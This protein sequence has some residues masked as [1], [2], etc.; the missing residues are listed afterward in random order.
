M[1]FIGKIQ[2]QLYSHD[3]IF[4]IPLRFSPRWNLRVIVLKDKKYIGIDIGGTQLRAALYPEDGIE[5]I[6]KKIIATHL[7]DEKPEDRL[8]DLISEIWPE[9]GGVERIGIAVPGPVD[10]KNGIVYKASNVR[11]WIDL[12]LGSLVEG[13]HKTAVILGNDA[14]LAALG[15]WRYGA[16]IGHHDLIY[17]TISTGIGGGFIIDDRMLVGS[18]GIAGEVGH[19]TVLPDGPICGCGQRGHL[20]SVASGTGIANYVENRLK[21][22]AKSVLSLEPQKPTSRQIAEA[23]AKGDSLAIEAFEYAGTFIGR[24]ITDLLHLFNPTVIVL[25]GGVSNARDLLLNPIKRTMEQSVMTPAYLERLQ[26]CY[27][28]LGDQA[29]LVG[30]MVLAKG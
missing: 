9:E 4:I 7:G 26:I 28:K 19:I 16:G 18:Q 10:P 13:R 3:N 17:L 22:G 11:G 27:A 1:V 12:P 15:E 30:A 5:P 8:N 21:Q 2:A 14:N 29:G 25:G 6:K 24:A 23:G 20:E